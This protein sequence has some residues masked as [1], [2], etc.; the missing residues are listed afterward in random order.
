MLL[1]NDYSIS[2]FLLIVYFATHTLFA[3]LKPV[4]L[5][6]FSNPL[7]IT[8]CDSDHFVNDFLMSTM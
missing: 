4:F 2:Y 1:N 8:V 5:L 7:A 3:C 6:I